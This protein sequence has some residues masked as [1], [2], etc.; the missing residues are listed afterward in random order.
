MPDSFPSYNQPPARRAPMP[1][2]ARDQHKFRNQK[3]YHDSHFDTLLTLLLAD[4]YAQNYEPN[5]K[6]IYRELVMSRETAFRYQTGVTQAP[7]IVIADMHALLDGY[8]FDDDFWDS[9]AEFSVQPRSRVMEDTDRRENILEVTFDSL[10][11]YAR[12]F[13]VGDNRRFRNMLLLCGG[14]YTPP[15]TKQ[16]WHGSVTKAQDGCFRGRSPDP[17]V[18]EESLYFGKKYG[19]D[20]TDW[21]DTR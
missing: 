18:V 16:T 6:G 20:C 4:K 13:S 12:Q 11:F 3:Y 8:S 19:P 7:Q 1:I 9:V 15:I 17:E 10:A 5:V 21:R 14:L 2:R